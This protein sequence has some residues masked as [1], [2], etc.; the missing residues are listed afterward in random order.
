MSEINEEEDGF[1]E[2]FMDNCADNPMT[3]EQVSGL[4]HI[5]LLGELRILEND[6]MKVLDRLRYYDEPVTREWIEDHLQDLKRLQR[7][8]QP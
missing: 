5:A 3:E 7:D 8:F 6:V 1:D 4:L 2:I